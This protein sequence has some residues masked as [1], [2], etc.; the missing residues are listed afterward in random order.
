MVIGGEASSASLSGHEAGN[1][2]Q[3]M[4]VMTAMSPYIV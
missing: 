3:T 4:Y 1:G 2:M